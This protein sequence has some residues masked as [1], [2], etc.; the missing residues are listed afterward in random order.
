M[1]SLLPTSPEGILGNTWRPF[2]FPVLKEGVSGT[3]I[4]QTKDAAKHTLEH[5]PVALTERKDPVQYD[6]GAKV[7]QPRPRSWNL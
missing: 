1:A 4:A 7:Q 6:K 5:R 2:R 3:W